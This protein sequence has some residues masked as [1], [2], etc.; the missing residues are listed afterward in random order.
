MRAEQRERAALGM[1]CPSGMSEGKMPNISSGQSGHCASSLGLSLL[2]RAAQ[3]SETAQADRGGVR[4]PWG[5]GFM[6]GEPGRVPG[7]E[8][9]R[10]E[11]SS[12]GSC[13]QEES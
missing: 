5:P 12:G 10:R 2:E 9:D 11:A 1:A 8:S 7:A 6:R 4:E 13:P 3:W